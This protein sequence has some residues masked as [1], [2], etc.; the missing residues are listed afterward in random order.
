MEKI[1]TMKQG[2]IWQI[3]LDPAIGAEIKKSRPAII[4]SDDAVGILPLKVVIPITHWQERYSRC[5]W[6]V[7]IEVT[8]ENGLATV[9]AADCFQIR[10]VSV[11]R[12]VNRLGVVKPEIVDQVKEAINQVIGN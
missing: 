1:F 5:P 8:A 3:E 12:L 6:M 7:K 2:E 4:I 9:S 10:S 11:R